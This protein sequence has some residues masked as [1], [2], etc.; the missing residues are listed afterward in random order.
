MRDGR[1]KRDTLSAELLPRR[2]TQEDRANCPGRPGGRP[3]RYA[4]KDV[5]TSCR[6][7]GTSFFIT[8]RSGDGTRGKRAICLCNEAQRNGYYPPAVK[9]RQRNGKMVS[10]P[11]DRFASK[12]AFYGE[13]GSRFFVTV[14]RGEATQKPTLAG[15]F[16]VFRC[17]YLFLYSSQYT[18]SMS[19]PVSWT[20]AFSA[21]SVSL[22]FLE[23]TTVR[24][25]SHD[26][27]S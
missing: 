27:R 21:F 23:I 4:C 9:T 1:E 20:M 25:V 19:A 10:S 11:T 22:S 8:D 18:I 2:L 15:R 14:R 26:A 3:L 5:G 17:G 12:R 16:Y 24:S 6:E 13:C 7:N